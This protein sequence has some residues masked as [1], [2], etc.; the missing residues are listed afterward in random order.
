MCSDF[1]FIFKMNNK[2]IG[3]FM[4]IVLTL[5]YFNYLAQDILPVVS[6]H[7]LLS[8]SVPHPFVIRSLTQHVIGT[9]CGKAGSC[10]QMHVPLQCRMMT[11]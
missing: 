5:N 4:Y 11:N 3:T 7:L 10:L 9:L 8:L 6:F 2:L 1:N